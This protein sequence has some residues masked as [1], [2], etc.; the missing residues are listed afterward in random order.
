MPSSSKMTSGNF[1]TS[2]YVLGE[3]NTIK[4]HYYRSQPSKSEETEQA[5][6]MPILLLHGY[7]QTSFM[8]KEVVREMSGQYDLVVPDLRGQLQ[9]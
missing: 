9:R 7:P 8:W 1:R 3:G 4:I 5:R 6:R 2:S